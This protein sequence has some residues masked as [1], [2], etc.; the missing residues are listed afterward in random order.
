MPTKKQTADKV[1]AAI[2]WSQDAGAG[3]EHVNQSDLGMPLLA[4][5]QKMS[6]ELD[7]DDTKYVKGLKVGDVIM[8]TDK[9]VFASKSEALRF[10][11]CGYKKAFVEWTPRESG[12]GF[13]AQHDEGIMSKVTGKNEKGQDQ[14]PNG[15]L[16]VPTAYIIGYVFDMETEDWV[17]AMI[18]MSSTQLKKAR[19]WLNLMQSH[20]GVSKDG[21][22]F[23]LPM[24]SHEYKLSTQPESNEHGTWYGWKIETGDMVTSNDLVLEC[25]EQHNHVVNG[26][27]G[28]LTAP[29]EVIDVGP[30]E[31]F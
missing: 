9:R 10:V 24:F 15:N 26:N 22:R 14:L 17:F 23:M 27:F 2:D 16:I 25:R 18:A 20:K 4:I 13:V 7:E 12:G 3:F 5:M 21:K 11:P 19:Q 31:V 8:T 30:D 6:P 28:M 1:P 29:S